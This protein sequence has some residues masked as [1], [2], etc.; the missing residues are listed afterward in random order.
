MTAS[1]AAGID[2]D[3]VRVHVPYAGGSFGLQSTSGRD[4]V[5]EAVQ[6]A[7]ALA[8][9]YPVKLQSLREE[10]F[11]SGR[12]RAMA[13]HRIRALAQGLRRRRAAGAAT[14]GRVTAFHQQIAAQPTSVNLPVVSNF[15]FTDGVDYMT[16]SGA[17][18]SPYTMAAFKL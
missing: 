14:D 9:K 10:E 1:A 18:N 17:V 16:T 15:L 12:Y 6:V 2:K 4:P 11:K 13:V 8:W 3:R 7:K 5:S